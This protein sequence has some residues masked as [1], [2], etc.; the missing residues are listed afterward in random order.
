ML[1]TLTSSRK[2][3]NY[4]F[5]TYDFDPRRQWK[6]VDYNKLTKGT[7][8]ETSMSISNGTFTCTVS[9]AYKFE[10]GVVKV[11]FAQIL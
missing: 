1:C 6:T 5:R 10:V 9:G 3:S 2:L 4:C 7:K 11:R 8:I